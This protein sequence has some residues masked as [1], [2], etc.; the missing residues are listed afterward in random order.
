MK[1][2]KFLITGANGQIGKGLIPELIKRVG[3]DNIIATDISER[4][5]D[6]SYNY[7]KLDVRD[8]L[9]FE[10]I[11]KKNDIT[12]ILHLAGIICA[13]AERN[14]SK[15]KEINVDS[16]FTCFELANKYKTRLFIPST[17]AVYGGKYNQ[18]LSNLNEKTNPITLYGVTKLFMENLGMYHR[19]KH[20]LD[21]RSIRYT[22]VVSPYEYA[23]NGS[24]Y[25]AT[26]IF[27]KA[28][29]D[30]SYSINVNKNKRLPFTHMKDIVN[31]TI[32]LI[33]TPADRLT[34]C[35]Y[36]IQG[37][38]FTADELCS[39]IKKHVFDF[40]EEYQ[41]MI[42]E[43]I[44]NTWPDR[45]DDSNSRKEWGWNPEYDTIE[46][47]VKDMVDVARKV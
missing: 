32:K 40:K 3:R 8:S 15:A 34:N 4:T 22:G 43:Y 41:P 36:N 18:T 24:V 20:G 30:R 1:N 17:I 2:F 13:L 37:L 31:G 12:Y 26:E 42:Q 19:Q 9:S 23:Y 45:V 14:P 39:E 16:V 21:F 7:I 33:E 47:L 5:E 25:Y 27:F 38:D 35:C 44:T 28:V 11:V 6:T 10:D 29:K 46:K